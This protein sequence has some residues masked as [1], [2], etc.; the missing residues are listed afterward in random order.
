M[1]VW[2]TYLD[3]RGYSS[4]STDFT[5]A[6]NSPAVGSGQNGVT[7]VPPA[8]DVM[9]KDCYPRIWICIST[10]W[11]LGFGTEDYPFPSINE[12]VEKSAWS[13]VED[14]G[15]ISDTIIVHD[16]V[17]TE[18]IDLPAYPIITTIMELGF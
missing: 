14:G 4:D 3:I 2:E 16:G 13:V 18:L 8:L 10:K 15:F 17:Y 1:K 7:M 11:W 12:A 5:L 9:I 6:E